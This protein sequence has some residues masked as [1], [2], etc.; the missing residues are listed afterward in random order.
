MKK[1]LNIEAQQ[2]YS[3]KKKRR[4]KNPKYE[5]QRGGIFPSKIK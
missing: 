1:N 4:K 5:K 2:T 3:K